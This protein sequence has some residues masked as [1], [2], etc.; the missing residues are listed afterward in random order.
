MGNLCMHA[1][2]DTFLN[3]NKRNLKFRI[4]VRRSQI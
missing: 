4:R 3:G 1:C 2:N